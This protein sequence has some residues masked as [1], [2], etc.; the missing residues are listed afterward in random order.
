LIKE[1]S[2]FT[3]PI[4]TKYSPYGRYLIVDCRFGLLF[5]MAYYMYVVMSTN[6]GSKLAKLADSFSSV[7]L[8][9]IPKWI[10]I[11]PFWF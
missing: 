1:N 8:I 7:A 3:G 4:S 9:S 2:G 11:S 10:V 6:L 5:S